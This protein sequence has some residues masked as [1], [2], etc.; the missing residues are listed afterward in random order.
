MACRYNV[1]ISLKLHGVSYWRSNIQITTTCKRPADTMVF[2]TANLGVSLVEG[3]NMASQVVDP[4]EN[5][6]ADGAW[7]RTC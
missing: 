4:L 3:R 5:Q 2:L 1:E 7:K 6:T